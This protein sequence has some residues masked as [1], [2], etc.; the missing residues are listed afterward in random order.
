MDPSGRDQYNTINDSNDYLQNST[1]CIFIVVK[2][3][4]ALGAYSPYWLFVGLSWQIDV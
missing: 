1:G 4:N 2:I 3:G